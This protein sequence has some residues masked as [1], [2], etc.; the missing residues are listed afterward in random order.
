MDDSSHEANARMEKKLKDSQLQR[1]QSLQPIKAT[2]KLEI[3]KM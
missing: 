3:N 2:D 1:W